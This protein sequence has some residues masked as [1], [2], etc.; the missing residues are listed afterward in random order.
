[1]KAISC[2]SNALLNY[3]SK[4]KG[5]DITN[6]TCPGS[7]KSLINVWNYIVLCQLQWLPLG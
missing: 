6:A 1:M 5:D 7:Y 2:F 4:D 3:Y